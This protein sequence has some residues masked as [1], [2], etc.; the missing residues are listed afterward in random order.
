MDVTEILK[1]LTDA[2]PEAI[3]EAAA[4][5]EIRAMSIRRKQKSPVPE[6]FS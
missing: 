3:F 4:E 5:S 2:F 6:G 1:S